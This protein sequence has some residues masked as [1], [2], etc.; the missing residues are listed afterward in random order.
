MKKVEVLKLTIDT[1]ANLKKVFFCSD[2]GAVP[3]LEKR[4]HS[5]AGF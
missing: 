4:L 5:L 1:L 2:I 3:W